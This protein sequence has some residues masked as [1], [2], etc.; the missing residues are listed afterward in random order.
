VLEGTPD[1]SFYATPPSE[2]RFLSHAFA[3][4]SSACIVELE[5]VAFKSG[6]KE[7]QGE[8]WLNRKAQ[9]SLSKHW[10]NLTLLQIGLDIVDETLPESLIVE[11]NSWSV[12]W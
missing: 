2:V 11:F 12:M 3:G 6:R 8:L 7:D 4:R 1:V 10:H 5:L 9:S